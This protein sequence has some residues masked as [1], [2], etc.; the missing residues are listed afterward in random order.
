MKTAGIALVVAVL[1]IAACGGG[2]T[3]TA[4]SCAESWNAD[5]NA[6]QQATLA[7]VVTG[8][9]LVEGKFRLGTW[10]NA[11]QTVP[12][13]NGFGKKPLGNAV[14]AKNSCLLVL[15]DSRIGQM[16]FAEGDGKWVFVREQSA[17]PKVASKALA[18][19]RNAEPDALGKLK[20]T[21]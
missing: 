14:V 6:D 8:D 21:S 13:S 18:G 5:A 3:P 4:A 1:G 19:V 10:P 11:K 9:V 7:G 16:A 15:P 20:L 12:A 17:F 2:E